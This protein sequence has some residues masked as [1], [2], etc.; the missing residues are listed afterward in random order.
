MSATIASDELKATERE[1]VMTR[2]FAAPRAMVWGAFADPWQVSQWWG[3]KGF[4][5]TMTEMDLRAGGKW[6]LVMHGPD[7]TNYP[8]EMTFL[9]VV[10]ME[11][12]VLELTGGREGAAPVRF[13]KTMS[14]TDE[15]GGTRMTIRIEFATAEERDRNVREYGSIEGGRQMFDRLAAHLQLKEKPAGEATHELSITR[16]FDAP[17]ELVWRA[18]TDPEMA[19]QWSGPKQF[20]AFHVELGKKPGDRWRIG[21]RGRPPGSDA[22]VEIWQGGVLKEFVPPEKLVYTYAWEDRSAVGLPK[23]GAPH[24]TTITVRLEEYGGKTTMHFHQAFFATAGERDGHNGGWSSSFER[25]AEL[26]EAEAVKGVQ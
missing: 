4:R 1:I 24:D 10:P 19:M 6:R 13:H 8:N 25:L 26:V 22:A 7:G 12:V 3:P 15:D 5:S 2:V 11:K 17:R 18:W 21:L 14:F 23:D 16:V 20:P 9:E